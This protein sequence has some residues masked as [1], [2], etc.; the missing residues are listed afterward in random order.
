MALP[1]LKGAIG[2]EN[3]KDKAWL[4]NTH[5]ERV[6]RLHEVTLEADWLALSVSPAPGIPITIVNH[7]PEMP[8]EGVSLV[9]GVTLQVSMSL[10]FISLVT[11]K[12]PK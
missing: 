4:T 7:Q 1:G 8:L 6:H 11:S 9:R 12:K 2:T 3:R 10:M 5:E